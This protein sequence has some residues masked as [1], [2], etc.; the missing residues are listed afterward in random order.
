MQPRSL[1]AIV[2]ELNSTYNPQIQSIQ[3]RKAELPGQIQAEEQGLAAQQESAFGDILSG[4][5]S[6]GL[7][8]SGIPLGEQ[9]KYTATQYMPA[10]AKLR[11]SGREQA[12]SLDDAINQIREKQ[13]L[14]AQDIRQKE[15]DR[16]QNQQQFDRELAARR[17][18]EAR[19][20]GGAAMPTFGG[21][22]VGNPK[23]ASMVKRG[24]GGFNFTNAAGQSISAA[25]F[26]A[27]KGIPFR[28][29]LQEMAKNGDKGAKSALG[30]VGD[31]YGYDPRKIGNNASV[32]NSLVWGTGRSAQNQLGNTQVARPG[33]LQIGYAPSGRIV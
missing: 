9:A 8:F 20:A 17:E 13:T 24:D 30:F 3:A 28:S 14:T 31:D 15:M 32:Y 7:G 26:A 6:R 4:A 21:G 23:S 10:L 16:W 18:S 19:A 33:N 11:M 29:L 5:R 22:A 1:D 27:A 25:A 2:A 12:R